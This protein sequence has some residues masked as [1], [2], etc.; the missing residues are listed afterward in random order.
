MSQIKVAFIM[1]DGY[2]GST[3][4]DLILG[5]HRR[6]LGLGEVNAESF[7][8]FLDENQIC[9]C[10]FQAWDCFFWRKV[11]HRLR[12]LTGQELFRLGPASEDLDQLTHRTIA[13]FRAVK[14]SSSAEVLI[15]SSKRFERVRWLNASGRICSKVIH[16]MRDGRGVAYSHLKRSESFRQAILQWKSSNAQIK[17]WLEEEQAPESL[18]VK[19]EELCARP[20]EVTRHICEFLGVEWEPQMLRFG[21]NV[22]HNVRGNTM[23]FTIRN[24]L[25]KLDE[26]WKNEL[27]EAELTLFEEL[28][29]DFSRQL[30][31][32]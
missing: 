15:D 23:R 25:I 32:S 1:G 20:D 2:S 31:Y 24:S 14:D 21:Q 30:G 26:T 27:G 9:T 18:R 6:M 8:A 17:S 5:T 11:L 12:E 3:L 22:H 29:G 16:L 7:D 19:Y 10:L 13:L 28:A 4:L